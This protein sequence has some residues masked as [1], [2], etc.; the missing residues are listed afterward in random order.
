MPSEFLIVHSYSNLLLA[1]HDTGPPSVYSISYSERHQASSD[2]VLGALDCLTQNS[3]PTNVTW[4]KDGSTIRWMEMMQMV[5]ERQSYSRYRN[6]LLIKDAA[7]LAGNHSFCCRVSN[8]A[9]TTYQC[10]ATSW[11]GS[12]RN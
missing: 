9:G 7:E 1:A 4:T 11:T 10:V 2:G 5:T 12:L 8:A 6:T 3:P